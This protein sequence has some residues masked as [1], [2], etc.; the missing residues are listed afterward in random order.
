M[1]GSYRVVYQEVIL[2]FAAR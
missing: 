2:L 1:L